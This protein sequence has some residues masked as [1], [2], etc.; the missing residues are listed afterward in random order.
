MGVGLPGL[1]RLLA[2]PPTSP[3]FPAH[4]VMGGGRGTF[5]KPEGDF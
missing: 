2:T 4:P 1:G 5:T 3:H